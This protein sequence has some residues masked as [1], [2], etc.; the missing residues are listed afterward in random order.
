MSPG[1]AFL[2][3]GVQMFDDSEFVEWT[4]MS[5]DVARI[6]V[7][8]AKAIVA[9]DILG[10]IFYAHLFA[11]NPASRG[12]FPESLSDQGR[13]LVQTLSWIIDHLEEN[14]AL[15]QAAG[16]LAQ[17]HVAYGVRAADYDAVGAALIAT[18]RS[19]LGD[20]FTSDDEAA[21]TRVYQNLSQTM[22]KA[23]YPSPV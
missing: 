3:N 14:D 17:R 7:N 2:R 21:W 11:I 15:T 18:L 1:I 13:K 12:M 4:L 22:I 9:R 16:A 6:R 8:W 20:D 19:G 5:D 23:A 10:D